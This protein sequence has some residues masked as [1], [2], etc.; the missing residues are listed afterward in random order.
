MNYQS[1]CGQTTLIFR[2]SCFV[3]PLHSFSLTLCSWSGFFNWITGI[4]VIFLS[5]NETEFD[6]SC[7]LLK[8][9]Y[10]S[11][12]NSVGIHPQFDPYTFLSAVCKLVGSYTKGTIKNLWSC[13]HLN[14]FAL[15]RRLNHSVTDQTCRDWSKIKIHSVSCLYMAKIMTL[16]VRLAKSWLFDHTSNSRLV[17]WS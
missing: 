11:S 14:T 2:L 16:N 3:S 6:R 8:S 13:L 7:Q 10:V 12:I 5:Q 17:A 9:K 1:N 15:S 4:L